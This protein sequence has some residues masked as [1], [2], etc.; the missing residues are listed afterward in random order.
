MLHEAS[1]RNV[2]FQAHEL[3]S[4]LQ[5]RTTASGS[6]QETPDWL[7][8]ATVFGPANHVHTCA[9]N[10]LCARV[11]LIQLML[12]EIKPQQGVMGV[13]YNRNHLNVW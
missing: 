8:W 3:L 11:K 7:K 5:S 4:S 10:Q 1:E 9:E 6:A 13:I 12:R 2:S